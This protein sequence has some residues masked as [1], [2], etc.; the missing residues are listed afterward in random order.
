MY[1]LYYS[2]PA[3]LIFDKKTSKPVKATSRDKIYSVWRVLYLLVLTTLLLSFLCHFDYMPFGP[4]KAG[5]FDERA[6]LKDYLDPRHLGNC[7]AIARECIPVI[8]T[9]EHG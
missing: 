5:R 9:C 6:A 4:T 3:E 2:L 7:F 8:N 1:A